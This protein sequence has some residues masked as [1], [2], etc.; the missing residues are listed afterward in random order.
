MSTV[1]SVFVT[2]YTRM[3]FGRIEQVCAHWRSYPS[4]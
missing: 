4:V 3:R 2:T 1:K